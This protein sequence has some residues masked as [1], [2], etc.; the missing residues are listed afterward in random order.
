M[1][2][3]FFFIFVFMSLADKK[4]GRGGRGRGRVEGGNKHLHDIQ[5]MWSRCNRSIIC[6]I[7]KH[8]VSHEIYGG[9]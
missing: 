7:T 6:I 2:L 4:I 9:W 3:L 5:F 8:P 1:S